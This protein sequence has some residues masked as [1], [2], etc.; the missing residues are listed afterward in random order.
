MNFKMMGRFNA[1]ILVAEAVFMIPAFII[2]LA[3]REKAAMSF[4]VS[5]FITISVAA[6]MAVFS[7]GARSAFYAHDGLTCV[8]LGWIFMSIVG[9]MPFFLSREI[10]SF[11]DALFEMVSGFTTTGASIISNP[12]ILPKSIL[13]WRSFSHW[14]GGMGVLVFLL[15]IIPVSNGKEGFT[16]HILRAESPGPDVGK[17][18]PKMRIT[19]ATL[20]ITYIV[21]TILNV[22]FL[23]IGKMP[24]FDALCT[25]FG[26]VG[27]G[28]FGIKADSIAGYSPYIQNVC[29]VFMFLCGINF[30]CYYLIMMRNLRAVFKDEEL[31]LYIGIIIA[32]T[33]MIAV[34]IRHM[35][36]S[37]AETIRHSLF[38]VVSIMTTTG[39]STFDFDI[40]PSF[41]KAILLILMLIGACAGSTGGGF[42]CARLLLLF[43]VMKRNI[44]QVVNPKKIKTVRVNDKTID[45]RIL[46]NTSSYLSAYVIILILSFIVISIDD[47]PVETNISA[48]ISCFNNIGPG[49]G[50]IG[51]MCNFASFSVLSKIVL[52]VD[53]LAGRLEIFP[54]LVLFNYKTWTKR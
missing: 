50:T 1:L 31:R 43:K 13:Y 44:A 53:M 21:I 23:L 9:C 46:S 39:F 19:A 52:I 10:P 18:V 36:S 47:F 27:T 54:I 7:R 41:S 11:I 37:A 24:L 16:M 49:F 5:I 2:G 29:T 42:K 30:S 33:V 20:Y 45:E 15:A 40:W 17:L 14:L 35:Y 26:T 28:G 34:N 4:L 38:Q 32:S 6:I 22:I 3:Y 51:P 8:G 48:V 25:A 12:E